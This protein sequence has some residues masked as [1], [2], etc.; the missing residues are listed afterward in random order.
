[1][2]IPR[3][4]ETDLYSFSLI[5]FF[6][7][8]T[9][10]QEMCV[11]VPRPVLCEES[12]LVMLVA[13]YSAAVSRLNV[14][15]LASIS[16]ELIYQ[17]VI[18]SAQTKITNA[19][20]H[21]LLPQIS[22]AHLGMTSHSLPF[23]V[24]SDLFCT[25]TYPLFPSLYSCAVET[26]SQVFLVSPH[27][28][29][30]AGQET[31]NHSKASISLR[32]RARCVLDGVLGCAEEVMECFLTDTGGA[33][34][35]GIALL[36]KHDHHGGSGAGRRSEGNPTGNR[37]AHI[38]DLPNLSIAQQAVQRMQ[39]L[40]RERSERQWHEQI[41]EIDRHRKR[42]KESSEGEEPII[43]DM[44]SIMGVMG[45]QGCD[46]GLGERYCQ[47][48]SVEDRQDKTRKAGL[49]KKGVV[50]DGGENDPS[51]VNKSSREYSLSSESGNKHRHIQQASAP[52]TDSLNSLDQTASSTSL[53]QAASLISLNQAASLT[54]LDQ[55]A[56]IT[57][58]DQAAS[59][60]SPTDLLRAKKGENLQKG[61]SLSTGDSDTEDKWR[62]TP[63]CPAASIGKGGDTGTSVHSTFTA[64]VRGKPRGRVPAYF[65]MPTVTST[66][67]PIIS[68]GSPG[69]LPS[70]KLR[71][72]RKSSPNPSP[73]S[74]IK[75]VLKRSKSFGSVRE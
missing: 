73:T 72:G 11:G 46:R 2:H 32:D 61:G 31:H 12:P 25:T 29:R 18:F 66:G 69:Q 4:S 65:K 14:L 9:D 23:S 10:T 52:S 64:T 3:L 71:D 70:P 27:S 68:N 57:S 8:H 1:M 58:L 75:K 60:A 41:N 54:S 37:P 44:E 22:L 21:R 56:S 50:M 55:A 62:S 34:E 5:L 42:Y 67:S 16:S 26:M 7:G 39:K 33:V 19:Y 35:W 40:V 36:L 63:S 30:T 48:A 53:N 74:F 59:L 13:E 49:V 47:Q 45:D 15:C 51:G 28:S 20:P 17:S 24:R 38:A 6:A 43:G